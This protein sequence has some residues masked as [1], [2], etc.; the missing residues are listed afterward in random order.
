MILALVG[1]GS[2]VGGK[3]DAPG[4]GVTKV[5]LGEGKLAVTFSDTL[6]KIDELK[7]KGYTTAAGSYKVT[8]TIVNVEPQTV[9]EVA[10]GAD[11]KTVILTI[12][13]IEK[14]VTDTS[15]ITVTPTG[16]T[17]MV[18]KPAAP[19]PVSV[20]ATLPTVIK[21]VFDDGIKSGTIDAGQFT[22]TGAAAAFTV[23]GVA[24]DATDPRVVIVTASAG[25]ITKDDK[26]IAI[27]Y[28]PGGTNKLIGVNTKEVA[29][30]EKLPVTVTIGDAPP[31]AQALTASAPDAGS[32]NSTTTLTLTFS[33]ELY[34]NKTL[35]S[36]GDTI[37]DLFTPTGSAAFKLT[38]AKVGTDVKTVIFVF[39]G[40]AN[41]DKIGPA[42]ST[43]TSSSGAAWAQS[44]AF[45]GTKWEV[46]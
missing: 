4:P 36:V 34:K 21:I 13:G 1:C 45:N 19:K 32:T 18:Y 27:A 14:G 39:E 11:D 17:P 20:S 25:A 30:F 41:A 29:A 38:S 40:T 26:D 46:K 24:C 44:V 43:V 9:T 7:G 22:V 3:P 5:A 23:T 42:A 33:G 6:T 10:A 12:D 16:M 37:T 35:V 28:T 8:K 15:S 2:A 31:P